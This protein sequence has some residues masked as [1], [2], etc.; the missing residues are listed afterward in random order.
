MA[1]RKCCKWFADCGWRKSV[2]ECPAICYHFKDK[3]EVIVVRCKDCKHSFWDEENEMWKCVESADYD[4]ETGEWFGFYEY[5]N[6]DFFCADGERKDH[7]KDKSG[8]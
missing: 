7:A 4:E 3:D 8:H 2:G 5:H 6:G 1:D